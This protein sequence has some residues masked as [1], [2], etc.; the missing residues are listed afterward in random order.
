[1]RRSSPLDRMTSFRWTARFGRRDVK[2]NLHKAC[3]GL[4]LIVGAAL[5][6]YGLNWDGGQWLH[7]DERQIYFIVLDMDWPHSLAEA[8]SPDSPLNPH[9]FAYGSLPIYLLKGVAAVLSP[10][11]P[12]VRDPDNLHLAGRLLSAVVD[13][14]TIYLTYRLIRQLGIG[15]RGSQERGTPAS[16]M[17]SPEAGSDSPS[18]GR[19]HLAPLLA[20]AFASL[21]VLQVQLAHFYTADTLLTFA[22]MLTLNLAAD[23]S[24]GAGR[25]R[26]IALGIT[27]GLALAIKVSA[28]PL[29]L[30]VL[31]AYSAR[32]PGANARWRGAAQ[33]TVSTLLVAGIVFVMVQPYAVIDWRTFL[34][35]TLRETQIARG[36]LDTPYT[37][38]YAGTLPLLYSVW[39]TA[40]WGLGLPLGVFAWVALALTLIRWLKHGSWPDALLLAWAG[41]YLAIAGLLH[42]RYLRYMLPLVPILCIVAV[43]LVTNLKHRRLRAIG[44]GVLGIGTLVYA[45]A[46]VS[47]YAPPHAWIAASEWIYR[48]L[49]AG[50]TL[51][52]EHWDMPLPLAL[53]VEGA[54]RR[55]EEYN[56]RILTLYDEPDDAAKWEGLTADGATGLSKVLAEADYVV[57]A[58]RRLYGS[59]P[60][61]P[62]RYPVASRYYSLLFTG[63]LGFE[64]A[65]EFTRGP[66]WLNPR[67]PPLPDAAPALL[68][69]DESFVV[70]DHPRALIFRKTERLPA[71]ELLRRLGVQQSTG[72]R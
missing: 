13:L 35:H 71:G 1:M 37:L 65:G 58:S 60:R 25:R 38:Q 4:I 2:A 66:E 24:R 47:M 40:L 39:Q 6:F 63:E 3:L 59:I 57:I 28:A 53:D 9:F 27:L 51:A 55:I 52:V 7:P 22:A 46:F 31:V 20:A 68:R 48:E 62:D 29:I 69:P 16:E 49:P 8:L 32:S 41:P 30:A 18:S 19:G 5:R 72:A 21:A 15:R 67:L 34:D 11:W 50:R 45:S 36:T 23:V 54:P 42:T 17:P 33:R 43:Q 14:G 44:I 10:L 12:A 61:L 70:Y 56:T 64:L 26:Q